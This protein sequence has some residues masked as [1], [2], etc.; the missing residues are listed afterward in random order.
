MS[1]NL[2][3]SPVITPYSIKWLRFFWWL[4]SL[5]FIVDIVD[6]LLLICRL[7]VFSENNWSPWSL[8][9]FLSSIWWRFCCFQFEDSPLS[10]FGRLCQTRNIPEGVQAVR[11]KR[12]SS[13]F[14]FHR[15]A[16]QWTFDQFSVSNLRFF[17]WFSSF[18]VSKLLMPL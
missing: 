14:H 12:R 4:E 3:L 13:K 17:H 5:F 7:S 10:L 1:L 2:L 16:R 9:N 18:C 8:I 6:F 15:T 11:Q